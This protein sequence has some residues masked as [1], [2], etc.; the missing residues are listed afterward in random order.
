MAVNLSEGLTVKVGKQMRRITAI[1]GEL[2][3]GR[4]TSH[5]TVHW[6]SPDWSSKT[7]SG[8]CSVRQWRWWSRRG[9]VLSEERCEE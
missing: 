8:K 4:Y 6:E 5:S 3:D 7:K 1:D 9:K 2:V